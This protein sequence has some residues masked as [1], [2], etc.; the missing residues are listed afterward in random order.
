MKTK[1]LV[2]GLFTFLISSC[3]NKDKE[4]KSIRDVKA[5]LIEQKVDSL[6][7]LMTLEE[8]IGQLNQYNNFFGYCKYQILIYYFTVM[9]KYKSIWL[10]TEKS[11]ENFR[12]KKNKFWVS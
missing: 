12:R 1:I 3:V 7:R 6:L 11:R 9:K 2:I 8:K 5:D 10:K 4:S